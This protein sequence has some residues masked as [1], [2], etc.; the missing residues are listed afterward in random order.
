MNP[1]KRSH[2]YMDL[3]ARNPHT[4]EMTGFEDEQLLLAIAHKQDPGAFREIYS[5]YKDAAY[6]IALRITGHQ[7][8]AEDAFQEAML[9]VW[10]YAKT[11]QPGRNP[12]SW[13][14]RILAHQAITK[15]HKK[16]RISKEEK[17]LQAAH[18]N[19]H[20]SS[21]FRKGPF[22]PAN[23]DI[24]F[25]EIIESLSAEEKKILTLR[26]AVGLTQSEIA[27]TCK[28][29]E[30]TVSY[31][32]QKTLQSLR[33]K[34]LKT[35]LA[36]G[37]VD[38]VDPT[39]SAALCLGPGAPSGIERTLMHEISEA[40]IHPASATKASSWSPITFTLGAAACMAMV[41]AY[42]WRD[43]Q[44]QTEDPDLPNSPRPIQAPIRSVK[45]INTRQAPMASWN[46]MPGMPKDVSIL[47][48][49]WK[50]LFQN[51]NKLGIMTPPEQVGTLLLPLKVPS[52]PCYL[53]VTFYALE[54]MN[55]SIAFS[56]ADGHRMISNRTWKR[57]TDFMK[58]SHVQFWIYRNLL[59][60][61]N[62]TGDLAVLT[63]FSKPLRENHIT[64][65]FKGTILRKIELTPCTTQDLPNELIEFK[66][67]AQKL[68]AS[69]TLPT[70]FAGGPYPP[71]S[72]FGPGTYYRKIHRP[73]LKP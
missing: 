66:K 59:A 42:A 58:S 36:A 7:N 73:D 52:D 3:P 71:T 65:D 27:Q 21:E 16:K 1:K 50:E 26:Y 23:A 33:A 40:P 14:L 51:D 29:P 6:N 30:R 11:Y 15:L 64:L 70:D 13:I 10:R 55:R 67:A 12:R 20:I 4:G 28:V 69:G 34:L 17:A 18:A 53:T 72:Q 44:P 62:G 35:G 45:L 41:T 22:T 63:E 47:R 49:H 8:E 24:A 46:F 57:K 37:A 32:L 48:G 56:A 60:G 19:G 38:L 39:L 2:I 25:S 43:P 9:R 68:E 31:R 54:G 5:R 61:F